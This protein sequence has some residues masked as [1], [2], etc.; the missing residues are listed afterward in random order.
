MHGLE[1]RVQQFLFLSIPAETVPSMLYLSCFNHW[2]CSPLPYVVAFS[3]YLLLMPKV[4]VEA[5]V[6]CAVSVLVSAE[7]LTKTV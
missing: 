4:S 6:V 7:G 1:P 2:H 3:L 5:R